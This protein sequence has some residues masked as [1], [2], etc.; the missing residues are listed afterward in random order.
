MATVTR[1]FKEDFDTWAAD[2]I[3]SGQF[4][5][6]EME[7][8]KGLLRIDFAP[9]PDQLRAGYSFLNEKGITIPATI[10]DHEERYR[11][12]SDYFAAEANTIRGTDR[13]AA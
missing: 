8:M 7:E 12:W 9:G 3:A 2:R 5:Q 4:T 11:V 13:K 1:Q 10:D 6:S